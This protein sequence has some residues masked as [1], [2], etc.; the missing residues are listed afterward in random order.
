MA[1]ALDLGSSVF[2]REGSSPSSRTGIATSVSIMRLYGVLFGVILL[3]TACGGGGSSVPK[4]GSPEA[5][6]ETA[7]RAYS[8]AIVGGDGDAAYRL[9]SDRCQRVVDPGASA[10]QAAQA[11]AN[12]PGATIKSFTVDDLSGTKAHVSYSYDAAV[13]NVSKKAWVNQGGSWHW[14]AC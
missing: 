11:K 13:L 14:D 10:A 8:D 4:A 3:S 6:L 7:V 12:Y 2:G 5:A 9:E 1:D